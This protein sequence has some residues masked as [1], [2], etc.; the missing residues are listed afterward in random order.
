METPESMSQYLV[1][2]A[3]KLL[4][5][6]PIRDVLNDLFETLD[7]WDAEFPE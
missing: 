4:N 7:E 1:S 3:T 5:G 6:K 2:M